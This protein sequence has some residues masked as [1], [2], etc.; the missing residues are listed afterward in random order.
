MATEDK[1]IDWPVV[2]VVSVGTAVVL[3]G[4]VLAWLRPEQLLPAGAT[5]GTGMHLYAA[6]MA[7]RALPIGLALAV[8]LAMRARRMLGA[9]LV[10]AAAIE[11][12]DSVSALVNRDWAE[13]S[14]AVVAVAFLWAAARLLG[15]TSA[16]LGRA[17]TR[18]GASPAKNR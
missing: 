7:A 1:R 9:L 11:I 3:A 12:G 5:G 15:R 4:G 13:L 10:L 14:G 8:L 2:V 6:R 18:S 16:I 17:G